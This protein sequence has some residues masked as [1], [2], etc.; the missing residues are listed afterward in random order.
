MIFQKGFEPIVKGIKQ[1][2]DAVLSDP[3]EK[4]HHP[5]FWKGDRLCPT[6]YTVTGP[7]DFGFILDNSTT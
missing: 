6:H 2:N 5:T 4:G 3:G 1:I 7:A